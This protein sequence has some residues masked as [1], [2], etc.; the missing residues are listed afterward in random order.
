MV[1]RDYESPDGSLGVRLS[2]STGKCI[3]ENALVISI[4][5]FFL[6][7]KK[8]FCVATLRWPHSFL[9]SLFLALSCPSPLLVFR[10]DRR[11]RSTLLRRSYLRRG[12]PASGA[13]RKEQTPLRIMIPHQ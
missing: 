12:G 10:E 9:P 1:I 6:T 5:V 7:T 2:L 3:F 11:P 13:Q 4:F 8:Y